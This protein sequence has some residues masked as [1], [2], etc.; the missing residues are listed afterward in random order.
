MSLAAFALCARY[1]HKQDK[2]EGVVVNLPSSPRVSAKRTRRS[3]ASSRDSADSRE[4]PLSPLPPL[5]PLPPPPRKKTI[6]ELEEEFRIAQERRTIVS[7]Q[8]PDCNEKA[9]YLIMPV[10]ESPRNHRLVRQS[11]ESPRKHR[12]ARQSSDDEVLATY[13]HLK[14]RTISFSSSSSLP[15]VD[16]YDD[17]A[18]VLF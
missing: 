8:R 4:P 1:S 18:A 12:L 6:A 13:S 16:I 11:N 15:S 3:R 7:P 2:D 14:L 5:P 17:P 10:Y 9:Q